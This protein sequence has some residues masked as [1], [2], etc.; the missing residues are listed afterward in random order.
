MVILAKSTY[1]FSAIQIKIPGAFFFFAE[2]NMLILYVNAKNPKLTKTI[3]KKKKFG[4][5]TFPDFKIY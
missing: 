2:I 3:L 4:R 5:F 1:T